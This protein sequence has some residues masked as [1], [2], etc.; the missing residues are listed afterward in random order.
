[1][2]T[3]AA[4]LRNVG[5]P[6][7][8]KELEVPSLGYGQVLVKIL[9][10]GLCRSQLNEIKGRKG[11]ENIPH[12]M[13]HEAAG[14]VVDIGDGV[15]KVKKDDY[16]VVSWIKGEGIEAEPPKYE[17]K[18]GIVSAGPVATF[19][20]YAVVSENRA[21]PI[22]KK[23]S[24]SVAALLG[25]AVLTGGGIAKNLNIKKGDEVAVFGIGGV[26]A[27][28]L[29]K[30]KSMEAK[31]I[32]IDIVDWKLR[33]AEEALEI[34]AISPSEI[35]SRKFDFVIECSGSKEAMEKAFESA[36]D[37][38]TVVLA[39]NLEP[40]EKISI[41]PFDLIKGKKIFGSLGGWSFLDKDVPEYIDEYLRGSLPLT[42]LITK[43]YA[44]DRINQG[45][46]DLES[47]KLI[48]GVVVMSEGL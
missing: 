45:L 17:S 16:V 37:N 40:G 4:V 27:S 36:K 12:L 47:G 26:G 25:C 39:G 31:T 15:G 19:T 24:P 32:A 21:V 14:I 34:E 41:N 1:M 20:E 42:K 48:K 38:G 30:A 28:A 33:W 10:S 13:G 35:N 8:I 11:R 44:F 18:E 46:K 43:E 7:Y 5:G 22:D 9:A 23:V 29:I 2:K 6:L 3:R